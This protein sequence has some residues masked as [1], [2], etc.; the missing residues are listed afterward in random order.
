MLSTRYLTVSAPSKH[1]RMVR[2]PCQWEI[3]SKSSK[4]VCLLNVKSLT[5]TVGRLTDQPHTVCSPVE[6]NGWWLVKKGT[7]Q[8]WAPSNYLQLEQA[9]APPPA[10]P[11]KRSPAPPPPAAKSS[12][13]APS[14]G[15]GFRSA[16]G[17]AAPVAVMPGMGHANGLAGILAAKRAAAASPSEPRDSSPSGRAPPPPPKPKPKPPILAPKPGSSGSTPPPLAA[18]PAPPKPAVGQM[19]LAAA[20]AK[21]AGRTT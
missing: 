5:K 11:A 14:V 9:P 13:P 1:K 12:T 21:R 6:D 16:E 2:W 20:L 3:R 15:M 8:G 17:S 19:D 4:K 18:K 7:R 10:P